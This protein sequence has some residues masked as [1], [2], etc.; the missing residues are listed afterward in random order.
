[1]HRTYSKYLLKIINKKNRRA[2]VIAE[3]DGE[4]PKFNFTEDV[5]RE[6]FDVLGLSYESKLSK[7]S[8]ISVLES[9]FPSSL[10]KRT[11]L[12]FDS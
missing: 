7:D 4:L 5:F 12:S 10:G 2:D 9:K 6:T 3:M 1:M 8:F 11:L